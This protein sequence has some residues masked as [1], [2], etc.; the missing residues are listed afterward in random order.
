MKISGVQSFV[1]IL[2]MMSEKL[3]SSVDGC[4]MVLPIVINIYSN[5]CVF[6]VCSTVVSLYGWGRKL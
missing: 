5:V 4:G 6:S 3:F 1:D 2:Q